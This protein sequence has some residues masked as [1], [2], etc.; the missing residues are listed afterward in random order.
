ML[1]GP[2]G[3]Q[4]RQTTTAHTTCGVVL[5]ICVEATGSFSLYGTGLRRATRVAGLISYCST[6]HVGTGAQRHAD[7]SVVTRLPYVAN[8]R[9]FEAPSPT[10]KPSG[11]VVRRNVWVHV[12]NRTQT[13]TPS[14]CHVYYPG[15][16]AA[17]ADT[18]RPTITNLAGGR[19]NH[20]F[21]V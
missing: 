21:R 13:R 6:V 5:A 3:L 15:G 19:V 8:T 1:P 12:R 10:P 7:C 4:L 17:G 2:G 20:A 18:E 14:A 16:G 9:V 11:A